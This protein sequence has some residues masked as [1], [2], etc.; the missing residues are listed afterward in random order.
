MQVFRGGQK[1]ASA[2]GT[3]FGSPNNP[4]IVRLY[5][6]PVEIPINGTMLLLATAAFVVAAPCAYV[7]IEQPAGSATLY[8]VLM[9]VMTTSTSGPA[10][11]RTAALISSV[12]CGMT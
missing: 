12:T 9:A 6:T 4:R 10:S 2:G 5:S 11:P 8:I 7:A 1:V 3:F